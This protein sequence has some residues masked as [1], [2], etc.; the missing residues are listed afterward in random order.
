M[1]VLKERRLLCI[2]GHYHSGEG[3]DLSPAHLAATIPDDGGR[4]VL[5]MREYV[6]SNR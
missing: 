4:I 6:D 2:Y 5:A 3:Q 1:V